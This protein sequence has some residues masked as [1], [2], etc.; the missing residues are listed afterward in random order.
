MWRLAI[1]RLPSEPAR[2]RVAVWRELRKVG[3]VSLQQATWAVPSGAAFDHALAR[4]AELAERAGGQAL[5]L[6][7]ASD[8]DAC[9]ALERRYTEDRQAEWVEFVAECGKFAAE[10]THEVE[11]EKFTLAELDEE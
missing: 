1:Y 9:A 8:D 11:I 2:H 3:A 10:L 5:V 6:P 7:V 4:A